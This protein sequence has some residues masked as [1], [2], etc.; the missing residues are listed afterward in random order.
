MLSE[1]N[2]PKTIILVEDESSAHSMSGLLTEA[3]YQVISASSTDKAINLLKENSHICMALIDINRKGDPPSAAIAREILGVKQ[4]PVLFLVDLTGDIP[5]EVSGGIMHYG[6]IIRNSGKTVLKSAIENALDLFRSHRAIREIFDS[7]NE[8]LFIHDRE[9]GLIVD[10]NST[11]LKMFGYTDKS[12]VIGKKAGD[13]SAQEEGYTFERADDLIRSTLPSSRKT[14]QWR[15]KK[16]NGD[17]FWAEAI[18]QYIQIGGEGRIMASIR[19]IT[20]RKL[21]EEALRKSEERLL[22][23]QRFNNMLFDTSPAFITAIDI[24]GKILMM[25]SSFLAA[26]EYTSEELKGLD[27]LTMIVP[28]EEREKVSRVFSK[29]ITTGKVDINE[30]LVRSKSGKTFIVEWH[31]RLVKQ[32]EYTNDFFVGV[33]IDV[34][35]RKQ[36]E[37]E[38]Q[39]KNEELTAMNEEME[40]ANEELLAINQEV[41]LTEERYRGVVENQAEMISRFLPDGT[42]TFVNRSWI[43]YFAK[44]KGLEDNVA[45]KS[46]QELMDNNHLLEDIASFDSLSPGE[47]SPPIEQ[48]FVSINGETHWQMWQIQKIADPY[49]NIIEYQAVGNDITDRKT[50][51]ISLRESEARFKSLIELA[52]D[53]ILIGSSQGIIIGANSKLIELSGY[54]YEE[55]DGRNI[56]MLFSEAERKRTPLRYDLLKQEE[57][58]RNERILTRKDGT[59]I[60]VEMNTRMMPDGTYQAFFR[61]IT[62]RKMAEETISAE[63]ERLS[64]TLRSIGDGVITTDTRGNIVIMNRVAE[65]LTGWKQEEAEGRPFADVFNIINEVT[66][67]RAQDP[68]RKVMET[69][70]IVELE[71]HTVLVSRDGTERIIFDSGAPIKD[72]RSITIGVILVFRD[73]T[74]KQKLMDAVRQAD[75]LSSLSVLAGGIAHDF[76]NLLGG[77]FGYIEIA[78]IK[79]DS[80]T[81]VSGYI[82]KAFTV[83]ERAKD[84][85]QQLLTFSKG[86]SPV[87]KTADI[88][89]LVKKSASFALSGSNVLCNISIDD[90]LPLCD[91][92]ENQMGQVIDNIVINAMQ[93]MPG[94]GS[95]NISVKNHTVKDH[96]NPV[97]KGG[98]YIGISI[99]DTGTGIPPAIMPRIFDPFFTTKQDGS[100]LGLATCYSII[101][102]HGGHIEAQSVQGKGT[103]FNILLPV[104]QNKSLTE[105]IQKSPKHTGSGTI[106]I[107]DD[108]DFIREIAGDMLADM[109]YSVLSAKNGD[110]AL[111]ILDKAMTDNVTV[112]AVLLDLTVPGGKG[113]TESVA[114]IRKKYPGILLFA[115][116]GFSEDPVISH[117]AEYGFTASIRKPYRRN[118]LEEMLCRYIK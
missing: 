93:S 19:D 22:K 47:V 26:L 74:E 49:K 102:K 82:D 14:T 29:I 16:K 41:L 2:N 9:T 97:L 103:T 88:A 111:A 70:N 109:G 116:S 106:L 99:S 62:D 27:Y 67:E 17:V 87:K 105:T 35:K 92:D 86:G 69:G 31:G 30:N 89:T 72:R 57:V 78:R 118:E 60:Y 117:P 79:S 71:E 6:F 114:E 38:L 68:V 51:E 25:N 107:M 65:E 43:K 33:G 8:A 66:R 96:G 112:N 81:I 64:V 53:G 36:A 63:K 1:R 90:D 94:G 59:G 55:L 45:G 77:I 3:G 4:L 76:N 46:I 91:F 7:S 40:A 15:T 75:K 48:S 12:E 110:E 44:H 98:K 42:I 56:T 84:L 108:E 28:E 80:D 54:P 24:N 21:V 20:D 34:T 18:L 73:I 50:A 113:G 95:I 23:E 5:D 104:S 115:S 39:A 11:M 52:P 83:F 37:M 13:F 32:D 85:T 58:V 100:G 101:S 10:V 61:D